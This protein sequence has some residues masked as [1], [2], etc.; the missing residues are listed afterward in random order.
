MGRIDARFLMKFWVDEV[1]SGTINGSNVTF[2][3]SQTPLENAAVDLYLDG[4]KLIPTTDYSI[5][6]VT[7]TMVVAPALAQT[8]RA[9]Y[10]QRTG[11]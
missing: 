2:T 9:D 8:L 3:L 6:G 10:I 7:I 1:P 5:S 11:E 4:I